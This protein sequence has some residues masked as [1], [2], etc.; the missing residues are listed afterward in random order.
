VLLLLGRG[1]VRQRLQL[2]NTA[3]TGAQT[4]FVSATFTKVQPEITRRHWAQ[5]PQGL[6]NADCLRSEPRKF[7]LLTKSQTKYQS[8]VHV[9]ARVLLG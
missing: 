8:Q 6:P 3:C 7:L 1:R 9:T 5:G 2:E 4:P